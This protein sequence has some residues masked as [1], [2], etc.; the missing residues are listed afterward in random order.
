MADMKLDQEVWLDRESNIGLRSEAFR[1]SI[2]K[3]YTSITAAAS[4]LD[5][6]F[7][8]RKIDVRTQPER[9]QKM[10]D[11]LDRLTRYIAG[12]PKDLMNRLDKPLFEAFANG[13]TDMLAH[14]DPDNFTANYPPGVPNPVKMDTN[15][16]SPVQTTLKYSVSFA[17]FV[18]NYYSDG[19]FPGMMPNP[20]NDH[21]VKIQGFSEIFQQEYE[22]WKKD[23]SADSLTFQQYIDREL[24]EGEFVHDTYHPFLSVVSSIVSYF[25]IASTIATIIDV[26]LGK[27][28]IS[29][30]Y[31]TEEQREVDII[32]LAPDIVSQILAIESGGTSLGV[33]ATIKDLLLAYLKSTVKD[34]PKEI[35]ENVVSSKISD[36]SQ[37]ELESLGC[38][39]EVA[40]LVAM[41][42]GMWS[43][44]HGK[45][46][47]TN[48][49][50]R[51]VLKR[52]H[53]VDHGVDIDNVIYRGDSSF[54]RKSDTARNDII[55]ADTKDST[56]LK[57]SKEV[58]YNSVS[59][60][61]SVTVSVPLEEHGKTGALTNKLKGLVN[62]VV[63]KK[64]KNADGM[65]VE[66][67]KIKSRTVQVL[68]PANRMSEA[69]ATVINEAKAYAKSKK[70]NLD[71]IDVF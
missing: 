32:M 11:D 6:V 31:L 28:F 19:S 46:T 41:G 26:I 60:E 7:R 54:W 71:V 5:G 36:F 67:K 70:V 69:Q 2:E 66:S 25:P 24:R 52:G 48:A 56:V 63:S 61:V 44:S 49:A 9:N 57:G 18:G 62:Q 40:T 68:I 1:V 35:L 15:G 21:G 59:K 53:L 58:T 45:W 64:I 17:D 16:G 23:N 42:I 10:S 43:V 37:G 20:T 14:L 38:P 51:T 34:L 13:P 50:T 3:L 39:S 33:D 4:Q 47:L 29:Q 22:D 27:D 12:L 8:M 65:I 55:K 30:N